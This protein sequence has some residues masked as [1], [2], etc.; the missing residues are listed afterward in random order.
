M[1]DTDKLVQEISGLAFDG[2]GVPDVP[3]IAA[4]IDSPPIQALIEKA[5]RAK[6]LEEALRRVVTDGCEADYAIAHEA[7]LVKEQNQ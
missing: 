2:K 5:N 3:T 1:T 4:I 7:L 6:G